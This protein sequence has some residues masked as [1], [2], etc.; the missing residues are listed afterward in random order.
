MDPVT[1][2]KAVM[3]QAC[4]VLLL[5]PHLPPNRGASPPIRPDLLARFSGFQ[6]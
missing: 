3:T 5:K 4:P 2:A 1:A 6:D